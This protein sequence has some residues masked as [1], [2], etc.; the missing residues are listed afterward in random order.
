[1]S[2]IKVSKK[3]MSKLKK[4]NVKSLNI[5]SDL[6]ILANKYLI[7]NFIEDDKEYLEEKEKKVEALMKKKINGTIPVFSKIIIDN[8]FAGYVMPY[9]KKSVELQEII[10]K[11][12]SKE[13]LFDI[14][15]SLSENLEEMHK[16]GI[17]YGD[18][19]DS[20]IIVDEKLNPYYADM[21][22]T[23]VDG[24]GHSNIP[25]LLFDNKFINDMTPTKELDVFLLNLLFVNLLSKQNVSRMTK[26]ELLNVV[27]NLDTSDDLK[28]YFSL[29]P[30][31][32][33]HTY[34][35]KLLKKEMVNKRVK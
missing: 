27:N 25:K 10:N 12:I 30:N 29:I 28:E 23:I 14:M 9:I 5:E 18:I 7:K 20:N 8:Q 31:G 15:I 26:E 1:M 19:S 4:L 3:V 21:D 33:Y 24:I 16:Q 2:E 11:N 17:I 35:T 22:G 32:V 13:N 34:A 6:Y